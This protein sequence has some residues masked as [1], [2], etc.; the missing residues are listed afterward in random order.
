MKIIPDKEEVAIDA[1]PLAVKSPKIIDWKIH[2]E[3]KKSYYQII[4]AD[5]KYKM[6]MVFNRM[7]KEFNREDLYNL[8]N[9]SRL[10]LSTSQS[11]ILSFSDR[12]PPIVTVCSGCSGCIGTF[13]PFTTTGSLGG[14]SLGASTTILHSAGIMV[15]LRSVTIPPSTEKLNI[16]YTI[17]KICPNGHD[18]SSLNPKSGA[19]VGVIWLLTSGRSLLKQCSYNT[20]DADPPSKYM[21]WIREIRISGSS[22]PPAV[23]LVGCSFFFDFPLSSTGACDIA[24]DE[25]RSS[26]KNPGLPSVA[27]LLNLSVVF[28]IAEF[29]GVWARSTELIIFGM[30]FFR[31]VVVSGL[32]DGIDFGRSQSTSRLLSLFEALTSFLWLPMQSSL[33]YLV[34]S[35][36]DASICP[37][38][39]SW[40]NDVSVRRD[41]LPSKNLV[42][43][44]LL[45]K[46]DNNHTFIR[47][48]LKTF[49]SLVG[50]KY[51]FE[52]LPVRP[53]LLK[54]NESDMGLLDFIKSA[55]L[56]NVKTR[57]RT[58]A[59]GEVPL[60]TKT[61]DMA[62]ASSAQT[63]RLVDHTIIDELE[64]HAGKKKRKSPAA[65]RRLELRSGPQGAE[66]GPVPHLI[67]EFVSS[68]VTHTPDPDV[69]ED[70]GLTQDVNVQTHYVPDR[71]VVATSSSE[72]GNTDV[73]LRVKSPLAHVEAENTDVEFTDRA[74]ASF[75]TGGNVG[76]S[77]S[78]IYIP[79]WSVT[80][81]A[82]TDARILDGFNVNSAQHAYADESW[83]M[84]L[85]FAAWSHGASVEQSCADADCRPFPNP[86]SC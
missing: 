74:R 62:V 86:C 72:H 16:P 1:I 56:F 3:G 39:V 42:D 45:E 7:L 67:E 12:L 41:P 36:I 24:T 10:F 47:Q 14:S 33:L 60:I 26:G 15:L 82:R 19:V 43:L 29:A 61:A 46:L 49:L 48:Y 40:Y 11:F 57:E 37:I 23:F 52:V 79:E 66:S 32:T 25:S 28:L 34:E 22:G 4:R 75:I 20:S 18:I 76:T 58:L 21:R 13:I 31:N 2:K 8:A 53:T 71:F 78:D 17:G 55:D 59:E 38:F 69:Y 63:F 44:E 5:R 83:L 81:D 85:R 77:T 73:S 65:L 30:S 9:M 51:S 50:L 70:S 84:W 68:S 35:R 80:N 27:C 54:S 6:Y 64:E